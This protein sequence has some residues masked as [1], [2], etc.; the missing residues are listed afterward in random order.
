MSTTRYFWLFALLALTLAVNLAGMMKVGGHVIYWKHEF[1]NVVA[2]Y[3][4]LVHTPVR[5]LILAIWPIGWPRPWDWVYDYFL[6]V[7]LVTLSANAAAMGEQRALAAPLEFVFW[8][9]V[10]W[11]MTFFLGPLVILFGIVALTKDPAHLTEVD[12][13]YRRVVGVFLALIFLFLL[14]AVANY[15]QDRPR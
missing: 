3:K 2:Y 8:N 15:A 7:S 6:F 14:I 5:S 11:L 9:V 1:A 4:Q 12:R 10:R 13:F